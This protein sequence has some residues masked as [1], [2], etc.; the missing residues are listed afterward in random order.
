MPRFAKG[1]YQ[2]SHQEK[3]M[4]KSRPIYRSSWELQFMRFCDNHTSI[5]Q[6]ASEP[7]RIPYLHPFTGKKTTYVPDFLIQYQDRNGAVKTEIIEVK[8]ANQAM[9]EA[10]GR[11]KHNQAHYLVNQAKWSAAKDFCKQQGMIFRVITEN[12]MFHTGRK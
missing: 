5:T 1:L 8:P 4:G 11:N 10:T 12:E 3:Y 9:R 7:L 6:W 2:V